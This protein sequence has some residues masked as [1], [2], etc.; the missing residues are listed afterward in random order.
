MD[1]LQ[2]YWD[3][4]KS[5]HSYWAECK[6]DSHRLVLATF[7]WPSKDIPDEEI[8]LML[9][10][11]FDEDSEHPRKL[12]QTRHYVFIIDG[13]EDTPSRCFSYEPA[14][15]GP[16]VFL[17][18]ALRGGVRLNHGNIPEMTREEFWRMIFAR[19]FGSAPPPEL[20]PLVVNRWKFWK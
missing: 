5:S 20:S 3:T 15:S 7:E 12:R 8:R 1:P 14:Y 13:S 6:Y 11:I 16:N 4:A 10:D 19:V 9:S 18:E 2:G 17:A